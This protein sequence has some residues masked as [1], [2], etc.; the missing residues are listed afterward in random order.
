MLVFTIHKFRSVIGVDDKI[1]Q[2][3]L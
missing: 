1:A 2:K 3:F